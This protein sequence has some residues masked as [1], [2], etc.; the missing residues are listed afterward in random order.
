MGN[1]PPSKRTIAAVRHGGQQ[2]WAVG[3]RVYL[4]GKGC[5]YMHVALGLIPGIKKKM[6]GQRDVSV[7]KVFAAQVGGPEFRSPA[8]IKSWYGGMRLWSREAGNLGLSSQPV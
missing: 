4:S 5:V 2:Y 7:A 3:L 1:C 8:L 6:R